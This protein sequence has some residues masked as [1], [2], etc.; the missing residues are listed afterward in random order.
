MLLCNKMRT[1]E[2]LHQYLA[3][4]SDLPKGYKVAVGSLLFTLDDKVVL[5]ER[6]EKARDSA[7]KLEGIGGG[8][9]KGEHDLHKALLREIQEEIGN[10]KVKIDKVLTVKRILSEHQQWWV[11]VDY[12]CRLESGTPKNME[13][14]K[15]VAIHYFNLKDIPQ[16]KL[17][18]FQKVTIEKYKQI[19]GEKPYYK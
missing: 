19:Y 3:T 14:E 4:L 1:L 13:P 9:D 18:D 8:V 17:S 2:E 5:V 10:V 16:D 6:G 15:C 11:V 12:L 7:G